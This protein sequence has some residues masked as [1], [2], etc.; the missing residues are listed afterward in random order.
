MDEKIIKGIVEA[1]KDVSNLEG[2]RC[3]DCL[4][5][6]L[7]VHEDYY[8]SYHLVGCLGTWLERG[9]MNIELS[10][11]RITF[12]EELLEVEEE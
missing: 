2:V 7:C 1:L 11:D 6:E 3:M 5:T 12:V 9:G 10:P 4:D 8:N